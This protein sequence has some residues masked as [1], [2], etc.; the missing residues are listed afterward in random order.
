MQKLIPNIKQQQIV[1]ISN[2]DIPISSDESLIDI[3]S[4]NDSNDDDKSIHN[5]FNPWCDMDIDDIPLDIIHDSTSESDSLSYSN[6][7][8]I[9]SKH[10]TL[11]CDCVQVYN[12]DISLT[13]ILRTHLMTLSSGLSLVLLLCPT[14]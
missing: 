12:N 9:N 13:L 14:N 8:G 1:I 4:V 6:V 11:K 7:K 3:D 10:N 2:N 5:T